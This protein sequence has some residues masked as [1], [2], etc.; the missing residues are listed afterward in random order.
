MK[1]HVA[2]DRVP[3][4]GSLTFEVLPLANPPRL[5]ELYAYCTRSVAC[6]LKGKVS[7]FALTKTVFYIAILAVLLL[8]SS[9]ALFFL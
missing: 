5:A 8:G 6:K 7:A 2:Q 3:Q 9:R 1:E 4:L